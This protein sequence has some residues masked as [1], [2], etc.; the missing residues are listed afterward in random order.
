MWAGVSGVGGRKQSGRGLGCAVEAGVDGRRVST[1][2]VCVRVCVCVCV[3]VCVRHRRAAGNLPL[4][5]E[6][7]GLHQRQGRA[8]RW[9]MAAAS[10]G[11]HHSLKG[12]AG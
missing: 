7:G 1:V 3:C 5:E 12:R 6:L 9:P 4:R 10:T 2:C 8:R 11:E